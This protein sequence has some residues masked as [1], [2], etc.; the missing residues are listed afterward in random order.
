MR[1]GGVPIDKQSCNK[2]DNRGGYRAHVDHETIGPGYEAMRKIILIVMP[3]L[4]LFG[5]AA[6]PVYRSRAVF[7]DGDT[8]VRKT[9]EDIAIKA[10]SKTLPL[11]EE[12]TYS[13]RWLGLSIGSVTARIK[14]TEKI[15]GR[16]AHVLEITARSNDLIS[17]IY[18]VNDRYV[19]YIDT[20]RLHVLRCEV[21]R[22]EGRYRKNAI[23]D[24]DQ[25]GHKAY[26]RNLNDKS[27]K[28][29]AIPPGVQ[30]PV[31]MAYFFRTVPLEIGKEMEFNVYNNESVYLLYGVADKKEFVRVPGR[32]GMQEA[33]HVQ[34][35]AKLK[36][37]LVKKGRASC[38][39]SCDEKRVPLVGIVKGPVFT[40]VVA[41]LEKA[42]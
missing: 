1:L 12:L 30:D 19:S 21:Y 17:A 2:Y 41:Y 34:P 40:E 37:E 13:V 9:A 16:D 4:F 8:A 15:Q 31:S 14:G 35:F 5:C 22:S 33:F 6:A 7:T 3:A 25:E 36:G 10:A 42:E 26:F 27:E 39:F 24:F 28:T 38:Y 32:K 18:P 11:R 20:E 23:T 29:I